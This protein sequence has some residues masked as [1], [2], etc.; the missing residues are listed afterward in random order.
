M[1]ESAQRTALLLSEEGLEKLKNARILVC[2][3]GGVGSFAVEALA[4]TGI[5]SL[6]L[7]DKD[8][9][10]ASNINR[11]LPAR[12]DTI[13]KKKVHVL[14]EH[15]ANL[16]PEIEVIPIAEFYDENMNERIRELHPDFILDCI[17][18]I[19]SKKDLIQLALNEEIPIISSMGMARKK[20]PSQIEVCE[21]EKT[22]YDP[23]AKNIRIWKRKNKIRKKIMVASS[24]EKPMDM[25]QG[26]VLP[27]AIF[28]PATAGLLMA[29]YAVMK[30][31]ED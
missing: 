13:G 6:I 26:S 16:N 23:I 7:I 4:R 17:D 19:K 22:S 15:V 10:E 27:S 9:V 30:L 2:G 1:S 24:K 29:N 12:L 31:L 14:K 28:V 3:T 21:V 11:Q 18:S 8:V 25:E 20:D 5:G